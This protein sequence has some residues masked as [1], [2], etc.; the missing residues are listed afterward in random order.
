MRDGAQIADHEDNTE[1]IL[2]E[3]ISAEDV[4]SQKSLILLVD[5]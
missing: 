1:S 4:M 3:E 2:C 5:S